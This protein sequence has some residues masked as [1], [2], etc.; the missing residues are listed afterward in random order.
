MNVFLN[1]GCLSALS[2]YTQLKKELEKCKNSISQGPLSGP[3]WF[4]VWEFTSGRLGR[5]QLSTGTRW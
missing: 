5:V 4:Q 3:S 2:N 1:S